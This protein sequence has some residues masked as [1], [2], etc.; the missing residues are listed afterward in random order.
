[1]FPHLSDSISS[2]F[3]LGEEQPS[4]EGLVLEQE[5]FEP[6]VFQLC[7]DN[8]KVSMQDSTELGL[9]ETDQLSY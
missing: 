9:D 1:M 6:T 2:F 3:G 7:A 8:H 4:A 5:E